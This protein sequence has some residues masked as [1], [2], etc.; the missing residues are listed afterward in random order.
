MP[1]RETALRRGTERGRALV[2]RLCDEAEVARAERGTSFATLGRAMG[3]GGGQVARICRGE[4][5]G[6]SV[7][8]LSQLLSLLGLELSARAF[9]VGL[10]IRDVAQV[11]LLDR[12]RRRLAPE[13][14]WRSEVS[15]V[16][17]PAAG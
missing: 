7:V 13:L 10:P 9:P 1:T 12:L 2:H 17:L 6:V 15:V 3:V 4:S 16:E 14:I 11:R 5:P 8:R